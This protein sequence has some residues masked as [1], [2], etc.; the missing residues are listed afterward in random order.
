MGIEADFACR[1]LELSPERE[2]RS[3]S[4]SDFF[5]V[6]REGCGAPGPGA[7]DAPPI[8]LYCGLDAE[9]PITH[10]CTTHT[11][12]SHHPPF[13]H[14][15]ILSHAYHQNRPSPVR[16][17]NRAGTCKHRGCIPFM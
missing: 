2:A 10:A 8:G 12:P 17:K 13:L 7:G 1:P 4:S 14:Y 16:A 3:G 6:R 5:F 15:V 9:L 11:S